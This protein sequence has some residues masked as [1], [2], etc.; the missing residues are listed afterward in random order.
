MLKMKEE[1]CVRKFR[2]TRWRQLIFPQ[3]VVI[4]N[5]RVLS[6]KRRFPLFWVVKEESI[7]LR[8]VASVQIN[9]GLFFSS[10]MIEN[11]GGPYP[12]S[13]NGIP[14]RHAKEIRH[15]VEN[16][17]DYTATGKKIGK[18]VEEISE[19]ENPVKRSMSKSITSK[20]SGRKK[21]TSLIIEPA[22]N[23]WDA[24]SFDPLVPIEKDTAEKEKSKNPDKHF[25]KGKLCPDEQNLTRPKK[26][27]Y[28]PSKNI[29][30][31]QEEDMRESISRSKQKVSTTKPIKDLD[32]N[33][34][35]S[36]EEAVYGSGRKEKS[37]W[38]K[39]LVS[40]PSSASRKKDK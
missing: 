40:P 20:G 33:H 3:E 12:I 14:N 39:D 35:P 34:L 26:W 37:G 15:I 18:V 32:P 25:V 5:V 10:V 6:R 22:E 30:S 31:E 19:P 13:V 23:A 9:K 8:S 38:M 16:Y 2:V 24:S 28:I 27:D 11:S 4:D 7:P 1:S 36:I 21:S 17:S 29:V